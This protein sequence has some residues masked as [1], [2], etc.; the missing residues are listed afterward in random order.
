VVRSDGWT[1]P[2]LTASGP[3]DLVFANILARP[4]CRMARQLAARVAPGGRVILAGLLAKQR[5]WVLSAHRP[6]G[7]VLERTYREG[8]WATLVL[9]KK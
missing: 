3:Y 6:H 8:N 4:L 7:L 9:K 5:R 1:A 2:V